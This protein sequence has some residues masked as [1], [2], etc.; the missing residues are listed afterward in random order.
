MDESVLLTLRKQNESIIYLKGLHDEMYEE[1][2]FLREANDEW[3]RLASK[4]GEQIRL[5]ERRVDLEEFLKP[6]EN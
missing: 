2:I 4:Y 3:K 5:L 6:S 1:I